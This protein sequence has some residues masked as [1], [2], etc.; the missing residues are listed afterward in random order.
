MSSLITNLHMI[1]A[2]VPKIMAA[3]NDIVEGF[4]VERSEV[5][6]EARRHRDAIDKEGGLERDEFY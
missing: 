3:V 1:E 5:D 6:P 4:P 2:V